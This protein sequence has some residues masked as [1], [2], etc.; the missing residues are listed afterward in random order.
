VIRRGW[1]GLLVAASACGRPPIALP[2]GPGDPWPAFEAAFDQATTPC[3]TLRSLLAELEIAGRAGGVR[4]RGR[5]HAG[6]LRPDAVRLEGIAPF[7][8]PL[9]VVV[10][11][12][13]QATLWLPRERQVVTAPPASLVEAL[14]GL[15]LDATDLLALVAGCAVATPIPE[16]AV[17]YPDGGA[18]VV[19]RDGTRLYLQLDGRGP[20]IVGAI[21]GPLAIEYRDLGAP[22]PQRL[23]LVRRGP[24]ASA[25][26]LTVRISQVEVDPP[27]GP[28]VFT[29]EVPPDA[30]AVTVDE[31]RRAGP[32]GRRR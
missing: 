16:H 29:I 1:I 12:G 4:L 22:V 26:D 7:G 10:A 14:I 30:R 6:F 23:R 2:S 25:V 20:R 15:A 8:P 32:F 9:F 31:L 24:G 21:R 27:L 3:R 28:E 18:A 13:P 11:A 17:R 5:L 19:L